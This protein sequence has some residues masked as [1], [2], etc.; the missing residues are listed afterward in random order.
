MRDTTTNSVSTARESRSTRRLR[1]SLMSNLRK[2]PDERKALRQEQAR[3]QK[4][5]LRLRRHRLW[6]Q[7]QVNLDRVMRDQQST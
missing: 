6:L 5:A 1:S 7:L 2:R 4:Q 3:L